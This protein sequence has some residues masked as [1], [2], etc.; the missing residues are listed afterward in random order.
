MYFVH[1]I[2]SRSELNE[3]R[4][5][6]TIS[7]LAELEGDTL[8]FYGPGSLDALDRNWGQQAVNTITTV[9]FKFINYDDIVTYLGK[10]QIKFPLVKFSWL[11]PFSF[12]HRHIIF[13]FV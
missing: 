8:F 11:F 13:R 1:G 10:L 5:D 7:H 6:I 12:S 4:S 3:V 2:L 9:S